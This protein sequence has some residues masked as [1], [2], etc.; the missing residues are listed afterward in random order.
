VRLDWSRARALEWLNLIIFLYTRQ[1]ERRP[2]RLVRQTTSANVFKCVLILY[3]RLYESSAAGPPSLT[4]STSAS[5]SPTSFAINF[6]LVSCKCPA[7][8]TSSNT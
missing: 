2:G 7:I 5:C 8:N 1:R 4:R 3:R 6:L